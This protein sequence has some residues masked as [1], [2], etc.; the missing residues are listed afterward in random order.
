MEAALEAIRNQ[1]ENIA[2]AQ[3]EQTTRLVEQ[4]TRMEAVKTRLQQPVVVDANPN[5]RPRQEERG[6]E[7]RAPPPLVHEVQ[8]HMRQHRRLG[9][10]GLKG[11]GGSI[12]MKRSLMMR[13]QRAFRRMTICE[14]TRSRFHLFAVPR[15]LR[16]IWIGSE[17]WK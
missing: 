5:P 14:T 7:N 13:K 3:E 6:W 11:E 1:L 12:I 4:A 2:H 17:R 10:P 15:T 9:M 8:R 16:L